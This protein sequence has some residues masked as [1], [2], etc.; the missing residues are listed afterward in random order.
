MNK[1]INFTITGKVHNVGFRFSCMEIAYRFGIKGSVRNRRD[2]SLY[3]EAEGTDEELSKFRE[4]CKKGPMWARVNEVTEESG[5]LKD[6]KSF[7][8]IK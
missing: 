4:W 3:V 1:H 5:E 2:G 6:Y 7:D 8:I